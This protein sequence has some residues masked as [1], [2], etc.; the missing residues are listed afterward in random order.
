MGSWVSCE[1]WTANV[2]KIDHSHVSG[3]A[4]ERPQGLEDSLTALICPLW[5]Y[6]PYKKGTRAFYG[7]SLQHVPSKH[8]IAA[9]LSSN[10][11]PLLNHLSKAFYMHSMHIVNPWPATVEV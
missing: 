9:V 4:E 1:Y 10:T 5:K 2:L 7:V 8:P 11:V 3:R 6:D